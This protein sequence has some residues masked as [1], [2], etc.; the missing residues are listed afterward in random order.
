VRLK[1]RVFARPDTRIVGSNSTCDRL[2][3]PS[4]ESTDCVKDQETT[5][6]GKAQQKTVRAMKAYGGV[7]L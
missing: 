3:P 2:N 5:K 6:A 4:K 1:L 7:D